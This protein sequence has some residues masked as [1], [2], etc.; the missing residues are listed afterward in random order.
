MNKHPKYKT[1]HLAMLFQCGWAIILIL[2]F[3][4]FHNLMTF[5]TFMDILFMALATSTVFIFRNRMKD[6]Q[7]A[8][9]LKLYPLIPIIYLL[10]TVAFV[11]NTFI[12]IEG[13]PYV[14]MIILILGVPSYLLFKRHKTKQEG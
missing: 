5:A 11:I 14:A 4:N 3:K 7:P 9:K 13:V 10:V 1:P 12:H 8:Y 2:A 6:D